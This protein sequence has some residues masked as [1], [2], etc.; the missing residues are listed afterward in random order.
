MSVPALMLVAGALAFVV[1]KRS[2]RGRYKNERVLTEE[3]VQTTEVMSMGADREDGYK[4]D[5]EAVDRGADDESCRED[6]H[7]DNLASKPV[8]GPKP[9]PRYDGLK[10]DPRIPSDQLSLKEMIALPVRELR[11]RCAAAG[12]RTDSMCEK[13]EMAEALMFAL[14][15]A[16]VPI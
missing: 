16:L 10:P 9:D 5:R 12:L 4:D 8:D 2:G 3:Q 6:K 11:Q 14:S 15:G 7:H 1:H 13:S